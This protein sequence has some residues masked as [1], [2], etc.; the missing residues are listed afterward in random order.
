MAEKDKEIEK[1]D[2]ELKKAIRMGKA[3]AKEVKKL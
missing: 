3:A 1:V 2:K